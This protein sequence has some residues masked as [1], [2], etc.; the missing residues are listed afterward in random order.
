VQHMYNKFARAHMSGKTLVKTPSLDG[1]ISKVAVPPAKPVTQENT[2]SK[3]QKRREKQ[4]TKNLE[5]EQPLAPGGVPNLTPKTPLVPAK[6]PVLI[7][8]PKTTSPESIPDVTEKK[9]APCD[10]CIRALRDKLFKLKTENGMIPYATLKYVV[11]DFMYDMYT[12]ADSSKIVLNKDKYNVEHAIIAK[13]VGERPTYESFP[14]INK[15]GYHDP[16][17]LFPTVKDINSI[18]ANYVYGKITGSRKEA[19]DMASDINISIVNK[20]SIVSNLKS[21]PFK[22][23]SLKERD[24]LGEDTPETLDMYIDDTFSKIIGETG[25]PVCRVGDCV[26]QPPKEF[27]G[28]IARIVFYYFLMYAYDP[29]KRPYTGEEPWLSHVDFRG[30]IKCSGFNYDLWKTFFHDHLVDYYNWAKNDGVSTEETLRNRYIIGATTVPNIFVGYYDEKGVYHESSFDILNELLFGKPHNHEKYEK[31][32]FS[33]SPSCV[34][35]PEKNK[36]AV[37]YYNARS[38]EKLFEDAIR[39]NINS[40]DLSGEKCGEVIIESN[41]QGFD[42]QAKMYSQQSEYVDS[43]KDD[44]KDTSKNEQSVKKS[45]SSK[46]RKKKTL[47][48]ITVVPISTTVLLDPSVSK[49]P[50]EKTSSASI[51]KVVGTVTIAPAKATDK[52]TQQKNNT[53]GQNV[54]PTNKSPV[55]KSPEQTVGHTS[56]SPVKKLVGTIGS[57]GPIK[58]TGQ[59]SDVT[60]KKTKRQRGGVKMLYIENKIAYSN[61]Q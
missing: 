53:T 4:K 47:E 55:K 16:H 37:D 35:E 28:D 41:R 59:G 15:E 29:T 12:G 31:M 17:I 1:N 39:R 52:S 44:P 26:F 3:T 14:H 48:T 5:K 38:T 24:E 42:E 22:F 40:L 56:I 45:Q 2:K 20:D 11:K 18:R 25:F 43:P 23:T 10:R 13:I 61:L 19:V 34:E 30:D 36:I 54:G 8:T 33:S 46:K 51:Q 9:L 49:E 21:K 58:T 27:S 32:T 6:K 57:I 50:T 7:P 60:P